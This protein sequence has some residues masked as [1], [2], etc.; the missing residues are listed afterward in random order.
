MYW[1]TNIN[2]EEGELNVLNSFAEQYEG[3]S[4]EAVPNVLTRFPSV[5]NKVNKKLDEY[6]PK[7]YIKYL[8]QSWSIYV[9]EGLEVPVNPHNHGY[10]HFNFIIYTKSTGQ[11]PLFLRDT[12]S[13]EFQVEVKTNDFII[14]PGHLIHFIKTGPSLEER[15]SFVGDMILTEEIYKSSLFLPPVSNWL[16][17]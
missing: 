11:V 6:L 10:C 15:I 1:K 2:L 12:N 14:L 9:P 3:S 13:I 5:L 4:E 7:A 17:L 8:V 16:R